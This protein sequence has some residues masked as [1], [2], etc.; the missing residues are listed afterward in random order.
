MRSN[1]GTLQAFKYC[2]EFALVLAEVD[3]PTTAV[4]CTLCLLSDGMVAWVHHG[5]VEHFVEVPWC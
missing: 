1:P 3:S 5:Q 2:R 4:R